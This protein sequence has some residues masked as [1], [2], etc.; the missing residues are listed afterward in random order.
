M[1]DKNQVLKHVTHL[2]LCANKKK[3][4]MESYDVLHNILSNQNTFM[5]FVFKNVWY[6][7]AT[8]TEL[9]GHQTCTLQ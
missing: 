5:Q 1:F 2:T 8:L 4:T 9:E 3:K 6:K 7:M